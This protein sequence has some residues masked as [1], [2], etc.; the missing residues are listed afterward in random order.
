MQEQLFPEL[1]DAE[2]FAAAG[3][4]ELTF[5]RTLEIIKE[6]INRVFPP[7]GRLEPEDERNLQ[8]DE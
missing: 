7:K 4:V 6:R 8:L 2:R 1:N 5:K 3:H